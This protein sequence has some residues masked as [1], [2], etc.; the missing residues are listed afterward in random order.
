LPT[1]GK[2]VGHECR[3]FGGPMGAEL[4][5]YRRDHCGYCWRLERALRKAQVPYESRDIHAD[6]AAAAFV[7]SVN[8]GDETVPTVVIG[9]TDVRTNPSPK[10]LLRD[11]G[12]AAPS[13]PRHRLIGWRPERH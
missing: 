13:G 3:G 1:R 8:S 7:R 6:P 12:V 4:I 11:L 10:D 5:V 2:L 9:G